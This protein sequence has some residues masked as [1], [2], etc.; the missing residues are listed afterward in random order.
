M[1][2]TELQ[3]SW[4]D[5]REFLGK[6]PLYEGAIAEKETQELIAPIGLARLKKARK[7]KC[8]YCDVT[9]DGKHR[10]Y[11]PINVEAA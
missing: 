10:D 7:H 11:C 8:V 4:D 3:K 2:K 6:C 9:R 1:S 5:I